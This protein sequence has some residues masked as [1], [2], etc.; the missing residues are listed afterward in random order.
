MSS[1]PSTPPPCEA[2]VRRVSTPEGIVISKAPSRLRPKARNTR[3]TKA[4]T[5]TLE[6]SSTTPNGPRMAV[7]A[8]PSAENSTTTAVPWSITSL[9]PARISS[10]PGGETPGFCP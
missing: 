10:L 5:H 9:T 8:R 4:F 1:V 2:S 6:P 7:A 3:A